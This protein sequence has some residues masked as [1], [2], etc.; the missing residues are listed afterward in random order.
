[1]RQG[2]TKF[3]ASHQSFCANSAYRRF[4]HKDTIHKNLTRG[5]R[6]PCL[7]GCDEAKDFHISIE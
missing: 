5:K 2:S 7:Y 1:M 4:Y 6:L 3:Q